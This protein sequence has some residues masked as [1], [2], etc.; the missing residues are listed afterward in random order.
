M[1]VLIF[2]VGILLGVLG[3]GAICV[4]YL[5]REIAADIGPCLR[6]MQL[7]L[8]NLDAAVNLALMSRYV[9]LSERLPRDPPP[10]PGRRPAA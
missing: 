5:R 9:E 10:L 7:Q 4:R 3:G 6:R 8:D 2:L 1:L